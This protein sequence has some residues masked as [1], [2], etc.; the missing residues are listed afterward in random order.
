MNIYTAEFFSVCPNN[1]VRVKYALQIS[2]PETIP[3]EQIV[4]Q[5]EVAEDARIFHEEHADRFARTFPGHQVLKAH[6]HGVDI[7]T[8]R[9]GDHQ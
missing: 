5:I 7:E 8:H 2:T 6:H 4:A 1:G 9:T 3:V